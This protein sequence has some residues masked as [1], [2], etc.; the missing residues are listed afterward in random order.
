VLPRLF[1]LHFRF[2]LWGKEHRMK[3]AV[4]AS[5]L[6][7]VSP[8]L[9]AQAAKELTIESIFA[10]GGITGRGPETIKWSPD[11]AKVSFV[12]RD[13]SGEHGALYYI[14]VTTGKK[15]VL[16]AEEKLASLA[17]P[18]S[19]IKDER[20]KEWVQ[21]YSVA[22]YQWAPDSK[23]LL[24][25][26]RGQLWLYSLD[27]GTSVQLTSSAEPSSDPK[28][29]PDG[30]HLAYIRKHNLHV[31]PVDGKEEKALTSDQD[32]NLLNGEVD[33]VYA[34]ELSV[35]SNYFWSPDG[36]HIV[37]LQMN[38][39]AVPSY[40]IT[41][42]IP[43]HPK[44]DQEKYPKAGDP[45]PEVRV[46][47]V[48]AG[49]G[50]VRWITVGEPHD[51]EYIPRFGWVRDGLIYIEL[52]NRAQTKLELWF[53]DAATGHARKM[54]TEN[55]P[56]AW[57]PVDHAPEMRLQK[58]GDG[59]VWPSWRDGYM[60]LYLYRFDKNDPLAGDARLER[61]LT[62]GPFEVSSIDGADEKNGTIFFTANAADPRQ[63]QIYAVRLDGTPMQKISR[64]SGSHRGVFAPAGDY[65]VDSF[66]A[67]MTPPRLSLCKLGGEC[68]PFWQ[69]R[70]VDQ[71]GLIAPRMM[72]LKAADGTTTL[73]GW[74]LVPPSAPSDK[75]IPLI[76]NPYGG[77]GAQSVVDS[78]GGANFLFDQILARRGFAVLHVDNRG[79]A[80]RG[81]AF[82][83]TSMRRFGQ[84]EFADQLAAVQQ[85]LAAN[86]QL[87]P[88]RLGWWGWSYGG[89]MTLYAMTHS[90]RFKAGISVAPVTD[91]LDYDSIYT[92]RYMGLPK[93][94]QEGY[95]TSSPVNFARD[96]K[97]HLL[98]VHGTSDDNVHMQ[99]T[100][101]M[102]NSFIDAGVQYDLQLYPRKTHGIAGKAARTH[103]F[104][105]IQDHFEH[106]LMGGV[107]P[108]VTSAA[109]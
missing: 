3:R 38:E 21:R 12:Q 100:I 16:V 19:Q 45:N 5:L 8:L 15:A 58:S 70:S 52:L 25:D 14:D 68:S 10:E 44:V 47:V 7:L 78:W 4:I 103:L 98:E 96:L 105:R 76:N 95:K 27:T 26:S 65:Y 81:K 86:P 35:R 2:H 54:L 101:Q 89:F 72:E 69:A 62:K 79:M 102:I 61:Q 60:H 30:L 11:G 39:K 77:P 36:K 49:G 48:S 67:K 107:T 18:V 104:H 23:H 40:P 50:K 84:V 28:F 41:D 6:L 22:G 53:A 80:G 17:P 32:E 66:S 57:V 90:D 87:D 33:W 31:R 42:W 82:A 93:E 74:L 64:E 29:S 99:N 88:D 56:D 97:G 37:F 59:F 9:F 71:Y 75:R 73:Y 91:W 109:R 92:E 46:G 34:E 94:N 1:L 85:V 108:P 63:E 106:W 24:F 83:V 20:Q 51:R 43:Q 13:D 55:E